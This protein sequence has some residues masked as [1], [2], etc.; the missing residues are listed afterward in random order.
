MTGLSNLGGCPIIYFAGRK[1]DLAV[2]IK[3]E[4][5]DGKGEK[6]RI[7]HGDLHSVSVIEFLCDFLINE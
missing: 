4:M 5:Y 1:D 6:I 3:V 7:G 2:N